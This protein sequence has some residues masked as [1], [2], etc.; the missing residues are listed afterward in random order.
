MQILDEKTQ[1]MK[2]IFRAA[3]TR[4]RNTV[5]DMDDLVKMGD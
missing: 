5:L 1:K 3:R 4:A 2:A